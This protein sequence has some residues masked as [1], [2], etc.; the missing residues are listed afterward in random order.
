MFDREMAGPR[1]GLVLAW[2]ALRSR[3]DP[4]DAMETNRRPY[5]SL[6]RAGTLPPS[7][8]S[9][10]VLSR[11]LCF[12]RS[13]PVLLVALVLVRVQIRVCPIFCTG[14][15]YRIGSERAEYF[16]TVY[17]NLSMDD[18]HVRELHVFPAAENFRR[19]RRPA[20]REKIL[21]DVSLF[22]GGYQ[23]ICFADGAALVG[24]CAEHDALLVNSALMCHIP[25]KSGP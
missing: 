6:D 25:G 15:W 10:W 18:A 14:W 9:A 22:G 3:H 8:R 20:I 21:S 19:R 24:G 11:E 5:R 23:V 13:P 7:R 16:F 2:N 1:T 17:S 12:F 4:S